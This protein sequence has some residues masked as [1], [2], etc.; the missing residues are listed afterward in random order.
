MLFAKQ[1]AEAR[2]EAAHPDR[3]W[4]WR[5]DWAAGRIVLSTKKLMVTSLVIAL[6]WNV[7]ALPLW[8]ALP[9]EIIGRG[10]F[11]ALIG[12]IFP[13]IGALLICWAV[14]CVRRWRKFGESEFQ[15]ADVPGVIGGQLAGVIRTT[16]KLRPEDGFHLLLRCVKR[17]TMPTGDDTKTTESVLWKKQQTVMHELLEEHEELS[18]IPVVFPIPS[19]CQPS[20]SQ[21]DNDQTVW[22]LTASACVP[23]IDYNATFE[24]PVFSMKAAAAGDDFVSA[25]A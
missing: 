4:M 21:N 17:V 2:L 25:P 10:N 7:V 8:I 19:D 9:G 18:A 11:W 20:N 24:V 3:P 6:V 1:Q 14:Y 12:F 13:A 16:A 5:A 15:M 23:G 22:R